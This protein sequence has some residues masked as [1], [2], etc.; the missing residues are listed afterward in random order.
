[1]IQGEPGTKVTLTVLHEGAKEPVDIEITRAEI[2]V[3]SVLGD[4]RKTDNLQGMGLLD[5]PGQ[6]DRL[7]P[8]RRP[9]PKRPSTELTKVVDGLQKATA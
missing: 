5:R 6:Q 9:S 3:D 4:Q 8:R 1:M 7:H 2:K